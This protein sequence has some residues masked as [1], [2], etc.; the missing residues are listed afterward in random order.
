MQFTDLYTKPFA[1]ITEYAATKAREQG[2]AGY[3]LARGECVYYSKNYRGEVLRCAMGHFFTDVAQAQKANDVGSIIIVLRQYADMHGMTEPAIHRLT[4][5][6]ALQA[7]HDT[8]ARGVECFNESF[9]EYIKPLTKF[10]KLLDEGDD[11][12]FTLLESKFH[13]AIS[14]SFIADDAL[15]AIVQFFEDA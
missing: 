1:E 13:E 3:D 11:A 2:A 10:A 8:A 12:A 4:Y 9:A 14:F 15:R 6:A 7:A 5:L